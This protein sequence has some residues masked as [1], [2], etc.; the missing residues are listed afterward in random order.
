MVEFWQKQETSQPLFPDV[1]WSKPERKSGK[2]LIVGGS[3]TGFA[4]VVKSFTTALEAGAG[5]VKVVLPSSIEAKLPGFAEGIFLPSSDSGGFSSRGHKELM[6][7]VEWAD[8]VLLI[9]DS[10]M[11]SETAVLF[12]KMLGATEKPVLITRDALDLFLPDAEP[13]ANRKNTI[14]VGAFAGVQ[15]LFSKVYYPKILTFSMNLTNFVDALHKFT[16]TYPLQV[17]TLHQESII[18]AQGGEVIT[19]K[20]GDQFKLIDGTIATLASVW[21]LWNQDK[22]LP[23]TATSWLKI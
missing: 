18:A 11:N 16:I 2:L 12:A 20:F 23:S 19:Q 4:A 22:P 3:A 5:E 14:V 15:K 7:A 8:V 21:L 10:A 17:V 6:G 9:G 1:V 13:L